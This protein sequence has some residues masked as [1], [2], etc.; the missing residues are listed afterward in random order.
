MYEM[1]FISKKE[2]DCFVEWS[3]TISHGESEPLVSGR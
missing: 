2:S 1:Y 3:D